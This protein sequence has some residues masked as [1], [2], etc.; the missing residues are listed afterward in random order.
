MEDLLGEES[1][2]KN[3]QKTVVDGAAKQMLWRT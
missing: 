1:L 2:S 3:K